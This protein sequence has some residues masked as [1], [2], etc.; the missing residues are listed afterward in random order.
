MQTELEVIRA[1]ER[2]EKIVSLYA[3]AVPISQIV[4][5][6]GV[7]K[8]EVEFVLQEYRKYAMQDKMLREMSRE[9][10][11]KTRQHYDDLIQQLYG[12]VEMANAAG[13]YKAEMSGIKAIAD[14]E[15]QRVDFMQKAGMLADNELG[16]QLMEAERKHEIIMRV[17]KDL[18][19]KYPSVG[20]EFQEMLREA[21]G[22]LEGVPSK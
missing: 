16:D 12:A 7:T 17:L 14:I 13:D 18:M 4:K 11:L 19:R 20:V 9:T 15:K 5:E 21:T 10:V 6:T 2:E 22:T 3:R 8:K 1:A